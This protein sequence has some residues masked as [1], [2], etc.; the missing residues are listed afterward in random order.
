MMPT[1]L[2]LPGQANS[3]NNFHRWFVKLNLHHPIQKGFDS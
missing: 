2:L 1:W 3:E